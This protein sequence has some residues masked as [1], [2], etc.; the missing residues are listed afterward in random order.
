MDT[1]VDPLH[2]FSFGEAV[3]AAGGAYGPLTDRYFTLLMMHEGT[4]KVTC[5]DQVIVIEAGQCGFIMNERLLLFEYGKCRVSWCEGFPANLPDSVTQRLRD[6]PSRIA[7]SERLETLQRLGVELG[8]GS[9]SNL[10]RHRNAL[11]ESLFTAYFHMAQISEQERHIPRTIRSA[12]HYI[13]ENFEK[14]VTVSGLADLVALTPPYLISAFRKH[15]GTTPARYL[16]QMRAN[17]GHFLLLQTG[18]TISEIAYQCGYKSP[19][20]FSRQISEQFGMSPREVRL[21]KGYRLPS[22]IAE[23]A[24]NSSYELK[25]AEV[26]ATTSD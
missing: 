8:S 4:A 7:I 2:G 17:R 20:H 19:F 26:D 24:A 6:V 12:K 3:Y 11:G 21:N 14:D 23:G 16:W 15:I 22:A 25:I 18:L 10:N 1:L 9:H 5:D 13:E